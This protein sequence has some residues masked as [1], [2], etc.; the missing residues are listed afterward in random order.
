[1]VAG[2]ATVGDMMSEPVVFLVDNGSVRAAATKSLRAIASGLS[3]VSGHRV[4]GVSLQHADRI[5]PAQLDG[6]P[7]LL[8]REALRGQLTQ[9]VRD[10]VLVPLFFGA[11]RAL[12]AAIPEMLEALRDEHG[13]FRARLAEPLSP[14]PDGEPLL[15]DILSEHVERTCDTL[16]VAPTQVIVVDHGSPSPAVTAVRSRTTALLRERLGPAIPLA[17]AV[18]E[19]REGARYDFNGPLLERALAEHAE[20]APH[21][22]VVLAM[23]FISPGR[24]AGPGGDVVEICHAFQQAHPGVRIGISPLVG[25]HPLLIEIL[26]RRLAA[27]L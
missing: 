5:S 26:R 18:M 27:Q 22:V 12:T 16:G 1:M 15:A 4:T 8:L 3:D 25:E 6:R 23:L 9:G 11:S 19:R 13:D 17:E 24:H 14:L 21:G 2:H 20:A 7:A 10:F